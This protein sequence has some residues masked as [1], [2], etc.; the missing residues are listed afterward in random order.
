M[1]KYWESWW[2]GGESSKS[3]RSRPSEVFREHPR[4]INLNDLSIEEI[5]SD[6]DA[7]GPHNVWKDKTDPTDGDKLQEKSKSVERIEAVEH[8][9]PQTGKKLDKELNDSVEVIDVGGEYEEPTVSK[10]SG[11]SLSSDVP[12]DYDQGTVGKILNPG[13]RAVHKVPDQDN[14][15]LLIGLSPAEKDLM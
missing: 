10:K 11:F 8:K 9:K 4:S 7:P 5:F 12:R 13:Q 1:Q 6:E 14:V 2:W 15:D 3:P